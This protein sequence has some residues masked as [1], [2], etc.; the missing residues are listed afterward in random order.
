[1]TKK[2]TVLELVTVRQRISEAIRNAIP[3]MEILNEGTA[4]IGQPQTEINFQIGN[5][6]FD[7]F[8]TSDD[9]LTSNITKDNSDQLA[10]LEYLNLIKKQ[11]E[12]ERKEQAR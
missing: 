9:C 3:E 12:K 2:L 4:L 8:L 1:M 11:L 5:H 10:K 6:N 7:L